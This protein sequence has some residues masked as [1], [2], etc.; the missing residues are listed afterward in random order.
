MHTATLLLLFHWV[1]WVCIGPSEPEVGRSFHVVVAGLRID[2]PVQMTIS[3]RVPMFAFS[4]LCTPIPLKYLTCI[5]E[6]LFFSYLRSGW[7]FRLPLGAREGMPRVGL[8]PAGILVDQ[9]I[10]AIS[11]PCPLLLFG[12]PP[13]SRSFLLRMCWEKRAI[14]VEVLARPRDARCWVASA[15]LARMA[16]QGSDAR[17]SKVGE[18]RPGKRPGLGQRRPLA[19]ASKRWG[20]ISRAWIQRGGYA[21]E[22]NRVV[23]VV[24][25]IKTLC[26]SVL[27]LIY[28]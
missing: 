28:T 21:Q 7:T 18:Q 12:F 26:L 11:L 2:F 24:W 13:P 20:W 23:P 10:P 4:D 25:A 15:A 19:C 3:L 5:M 17:T 1:P 9:P 14:V 16:R 8:P 6:T 22:K 27:N